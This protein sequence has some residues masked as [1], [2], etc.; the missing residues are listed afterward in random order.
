MTVT[1]V[2]MDGMVLGTKT[3]VVEP[4]GLKQTNSVVQYLYDS[5]GG[6]T[7]G[8]LYLESDQAVSAWASQ[9]DN[10]TND[11][12]LLVSKR[13]GATKILVPSAA[14]TSTFK[15]SLVLM[16]VGLSAA[17][18]AIKAYDVN[19]TA[20]GQ[21]SSNLSIPANGVLS[22][23]NVLES[24]GVVNNFGPIEITSLNNVPLIAASRVSSTNRAG[25]FFEGLRYSEAS[26]VQVIPHVVDTLELRTNIG[27]NNVTDSAATVMV[28]LFNK[29]GVE[30]GA[31]SVT[32]SAK[33]LS[34]IN[35]VVRSLLNRSDLTNVE[36]YIR[37]ESNQPIFGW[38]S[39]I[40]NVTNDPGFAVE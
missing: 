27:I 31:A 21:T 22:F 36:G 25:G 7:Q 4:G 32:V 1:L 19:G 9:I 20:L 34:Q 14:N 18:V 40:D 12:S 26:L 6:E 35:H 8:N 2:D 37:L 11:P 16:N 24:L 23:S 3:L 15:S 39:Q 29:D 13:L 30:L 17:S 10:V 28:R 38:A 5:L 33:G